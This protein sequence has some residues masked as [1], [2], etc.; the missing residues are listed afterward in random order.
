MYPPD[1]IYGIFHNYI[2]PFIHIFA[3]GHIFIINLICGVSSWFIYGLFINDMG[4]IER[5]EHILC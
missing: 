3:V 4:K 5:T 2:S 1:T